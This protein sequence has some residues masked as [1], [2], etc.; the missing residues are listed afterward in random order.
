M[1]SSLKI[2]LRILSFKKI[3]K[4]LQS[5]NSWN[6]NPLHLEPWFV[7]LSDNH[8]EP[9]AGGVGL[10]LVEDASAIFRMPTV[11][12]RSIHPVEK[13]LALM[14]KS[15]GPNT[16]P[17]R[18]SPWRTGREWAAPG[19]HRAPGSWNPR[20]LPGSCR[21]SS[22]KSGAARRRRLVL[23]DS[24][25]SPRRMEIHCELTHTVGDDDCEIRQTCEAELWAGGLLI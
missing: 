12:A 18:A 24:K 7:V 14:A 2:F 9:V 3:S 15:R 8:C 4:L 1:T 5:S 21:G 20:G 11:A 10:V 17:S 25:D 16:G 13:M 23:V 22:P 19:P 6:P